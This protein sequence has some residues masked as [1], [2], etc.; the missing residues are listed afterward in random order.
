MSK[1]LR[2]AKIIMSLKSVFQ[3]RKTLA[4]G[5][6]GNMAKRSGVHWQLGMCALRALSII[7]QL[8]LSGPDSQGISAQ[9]SVSSFPSPSSSIQKSLS[10]QGILLRQ[11][12]AL[13][14][15]YFLFCPAYRENTKH[16]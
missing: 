8:L 13:E 6:A 7:H 12:N 15:S 14:M 5:V 3:V 9:T 4:S 10:F 11:E 1:V 16:P 2:L